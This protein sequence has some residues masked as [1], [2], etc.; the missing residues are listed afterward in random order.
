VEILRN[1]RAA[2]G[3]GATVL[4]VGLVIPEHNREFLGKWMDL[5]ML[6]CAAARERTA[7]EYRD[8]LQEGG[9]PMTRVVQTASPFS[10]VEAKAA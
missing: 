5:E 6:L 4:L 10:I 3:T 9:F 2:A 1:V 7:A 8:L